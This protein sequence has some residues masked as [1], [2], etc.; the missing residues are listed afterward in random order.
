MHQILK[1]FWQHKLFPQL[2]YPVSLD[3]VLAQKEVFF[4]LRNKRKQLMFQ[5]LF[6]SKQIL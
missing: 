4:Q 3:I 1:I 6:K 5:E 2:C